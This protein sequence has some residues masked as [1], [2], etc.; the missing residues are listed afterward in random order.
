MTAVV[1][2]RCAECGRR[3]ISR[4]D[5]FEGIAGCNQETAAA[6]AECLATQLRQH[7]T[8]LALAMRVAKAASDVICG[9]TPIVN[10]VLPETITSLRTALDELDEASKAHEKPSDV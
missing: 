6:N 7:Q 9:Y 3:K 5:W 10:R 1:S 4:I 8:R 2:D